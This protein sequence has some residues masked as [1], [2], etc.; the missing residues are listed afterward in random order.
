MM[1]RSVS[2]THRIPALLDIYR[3]A[4]MLIRQHG[5]AA[6]LVA[7]QRADEMLAKGDI[8]GK[9]TWI[10]IMRAVEELQRQRRSGEQIN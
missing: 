3:S 2:K 4:Q 8:S 10:A 1:R 9:A 7:A 6:S 5:D